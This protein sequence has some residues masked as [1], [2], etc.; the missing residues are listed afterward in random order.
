MSY[1]TTLLKET[2]NIISIIKS[3]ILEIIKTNENILAFDNLDEF[4]L[5]RVEENFKRIEQKENEIKYY[6]QELQEVL[7]MDNAA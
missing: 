6:N 4:D 5:K 2:K 1:K 3:E 7:K